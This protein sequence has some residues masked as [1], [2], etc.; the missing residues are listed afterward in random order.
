MQTLSASFQRFVQRGT[1]HECFELFP[2]CFKATS[3]VLY[4]TDISALRMYFCPLLPAVLGQ[5]EKE[6]KVQ[7]LGRVIDQIKNTDLTR[8]HDLPQALRVFSPMDI[9]T[10]ASTVYRVV[11]Q[12]SDQTG[13]LYRHYVI[14]FGDLIDRYIVALPVKRSGRRGL[15]CKTIAYGDIAKACSTTQTAIADTYTQCGRYI[16]CLEIGGPGSLRSIVCAKSE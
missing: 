16:R 7:R 1:P 6:A 15:G 5:K 8:K 12:L 11:E 9:F 14:L 13:L 3:K 10:L 4:T 2:E